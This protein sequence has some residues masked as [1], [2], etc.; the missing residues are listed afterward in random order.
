MNVGR[1]RS[2][3]RRLAYIAALALIVIILS[4]IGLLRSGQTDPIVGDWNVSYGAPAVVTMT[5]SGGSYTETAKT[6]LQVTGGPCYLPVGTII[7]TFRSTGGKSY[8]GRHGLWDRSSCAFASWAGLTLTLSTDGNKLTA[9]IG[10]GYETHPFTKDGNGTSLS[11]GASIGLLAALVAVVGAVVVAVTRRGQ[12][13]TLPNRPTSAPAGWYPDTAV[14]VQRYWDG[15][16]W[17]EH[18]APL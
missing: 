18:T 10:G 6:P 4:G 17:T 11:Y 7:A 5:L 9:V 16:R 12:A 14:G 2:H 1:S 13:E 8:S 15:Q 3:G